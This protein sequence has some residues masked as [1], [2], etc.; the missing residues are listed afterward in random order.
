MDLISKIIPKKI[1]IIELIIII[2]AMLVTILPFI[3][4]Y[5]IMIYSEIKIFVINDYLLGWIL[6]TFMTVIFLLLEIILLIYIFG[7][8]RIK[9]DLSPL[10]TVI[11]AVVGHIVFT[12]FAYVVIWLSLLTKLEN[13]FYGFLVIFIIEISILSYL[14]VIFKKQERI[15]R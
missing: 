7:N 2:F 6:F 11:A 3:M 15:I 4:A 9:Y 12:A 10:S 5:Q 13:A 8:A 1:L 14:I